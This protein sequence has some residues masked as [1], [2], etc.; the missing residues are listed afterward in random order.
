MMKF[1]TLVLLSALMPSTIAS[2][3]PSRLPFIDDDY[4]RARAEATQR[5]LPLFVDVW[6]PW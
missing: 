1:S 3:A 4:A 2:A 5:K 6:A